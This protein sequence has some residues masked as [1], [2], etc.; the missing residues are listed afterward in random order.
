MRLGCHVRLGIGINL[1]QYN[2]GMRINQAYRISCH[3]LLP[4]S[5]RRNT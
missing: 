2:D 1:T 4:R 5:V 3:T